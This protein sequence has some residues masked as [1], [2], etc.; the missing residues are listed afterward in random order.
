M[1]MRKNQG[2]TLIE[3]IAVIAIL[4]I[5]AATAIP[6]FV[7]LRTDA[8]RAATAGVAGAL[9]SAASLAYAKSVATGTSASPVLNCQALT[10]ASGFI[11]GATV[12]AS[13]AAAGQYGLDSTVLTSGQVG[14]CTLHNGDDANATVTFSAIGN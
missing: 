10:T 3:L 11:Q 8:R 5:L 12:V 14:T 7:D 4:A 13:P 9:S 2:F 6:Q 1:K